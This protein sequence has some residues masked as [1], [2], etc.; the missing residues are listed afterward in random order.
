MSTVNDRK[1]LE[2][3]QFLFNSGEQ[4]KFVYFWGHQAPR[5]GSIS[6]TCF[7]Q[8]YHSPFD[9]EGVTY[10]TAEHYMMAAKARLFNDQDACQR[11]LASKTPGE[12][13]AEGR[14][15]LNFKEEIWLTHR[16]EIV[17]RANEAK[18]GQHSSMQQYL[19]QTGDRV[20]VE[21]SPTDRIWGI[22]L[23]S[24]DEDAK[25]PNKWRGLNLLGFALMHA[26]RQFQRGI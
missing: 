2:D 24:S 8:W 21:A 11:V 19:V 3:L 12:A 13:K 20:L 14:K 26:R 6:Q 22:G 17:C 9:E 5:D 10:L 18:F 4:M 15:V 1:F 7:S 25:D 23:A 16:F